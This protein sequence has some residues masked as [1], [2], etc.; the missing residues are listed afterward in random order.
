MDWSLHCSKK[1]DTST[2]RGFISL[3][4]YTVAP[5]PGPWAGYFGGRVWSNEERDQMSTRGASL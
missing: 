4:L 1:I 2:N 3:Q 5:T